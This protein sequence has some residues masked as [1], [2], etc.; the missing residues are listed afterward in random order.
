M[1]SAT[2]GSLFT[3]LIDV[4]FTVEA[5]PVAKGRPRARIFNGRVHLYTPPKTKYFEQRVH[6]AA[7][8][9]PLPQIGV[10][11]RVDI[12]AICKRPKRL[13]RKKDPDS[14]IYRPSKPDG[15]NVR[16]AILDGLSNFFDDKQVV[17]GETVCLYAEKNRDIGRCVIRVTTKLETEEQILPR[18]DLLNDCEY[19]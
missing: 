16:K 17:S 14:L 2:S 18:L 15:D 13:C 6:R 7:Q 1:N 10:P 19:Q 12:I 4:T 5:E 8:R 3:D 9:V 11:L